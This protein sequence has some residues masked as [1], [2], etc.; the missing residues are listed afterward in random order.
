MLTDQNIEAELSYAYLHA[1]ATERGSRANT[2]TGTW[3][4]PQSMRSFAR[5]A[6]FWR[7]TRIWP[8]SSLR[9]QLKATYQRLARIQGS[10]VLSASPHA[11][12]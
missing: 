7:T 12:Q 9:I 8:R 10:L 4:M 11:I 2:R 6:V 5:K 3:I 1:V